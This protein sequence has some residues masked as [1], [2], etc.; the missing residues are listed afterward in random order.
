MNDALVVTALGMAV[1]FS[2]LVLTALLIM[3]FGALARR[4]E[5]RAAEALQPP[6]PPA[7]AIAS[8]PVDE[9]VLAVIS[10][11]LE[12]ERRLH[13]AEVTGRLTIVR[14]GDARRPS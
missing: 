13:N 11:V 2:G 6:S 1:V 7:A 4:D 8:G 14:A 12:I 10:A 9:P 5:R 3:T